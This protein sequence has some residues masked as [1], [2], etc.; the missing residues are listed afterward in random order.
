MF[1]KKPGSIALSL[2]GRITFACQRG[3]KAD[4]GKVRQPPAVIYL[5]IE[6]GMSF[7]KGSPKKDEI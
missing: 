5:S 4:D 3:A 1:S 2:Q 7:G 6:L